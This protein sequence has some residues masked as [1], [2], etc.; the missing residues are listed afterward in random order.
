MNMRPSSP[1]R[2]TI[3]KTCPA[4]ALSILYGTLSGVTFTPVILWLPQ[5]FDKRMG[6]ASGIIYSGSG[7]GGTLFPIAINHALESVGFAW[8][9]RLSAAWGLI[10]AGGAAFFLKPR[11]PITRPNTRPRSMIRAL[12]PEGLGSLLH[13]FAVTQVVLVVCQASA[14]CT[15]SLYLATWTSS[16]G[17]SATTSTGV[18]SGFNA[19][20]TIG[21]LVTGRLIDSMPY[22]V[23][24]SGSTLIC[25]L[26]AYLL[27]G[28][29][30][31]LP[32]IIIFSLIFGAAGGGFTT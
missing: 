3:V 23:L 10:L 27:L 17:F 15:I 6:F 29:S 11:L 21:Y 13:P 5:W 25:G 7:A 20:A 22:L 14:W 16:L 24:M 18:L 1:C 2:L 4:P 12:A 9:L 28:F 8:T 32:L 19:A 30:H 26:S 31:S